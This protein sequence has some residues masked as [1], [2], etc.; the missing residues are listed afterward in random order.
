[1]ELRPLPFSGGPIFALIFWG[2]FAVWVLPEIIASKT[3]RSLGSS[4]V[5]DRGSLYLIA[6]LWWSGIVAD[7]LL[8]LLAPQAAI[9]STRT[10]VFFAGICLMILGTAFRWYCVR[11]LGKYFTFDVATHNG[12]VLIEVGPYRYIRHPSYSGALVTLIGFGLALGNWAGLAVVL[13]CLGFAYAYRIPV[14]E[15]ALTKAL[16]DAYKQYKKRTWRLIPLVF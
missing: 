2:A 13:L 6:A 9:T 12:Q 15:A 5:R 7:F 8:S 10:A 11:V 4:N 16:G 14:E 3:K 1:M